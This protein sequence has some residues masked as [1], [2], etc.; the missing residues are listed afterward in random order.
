MKFYFVRFKDT[1]NKVYDGIMIGRLI[2]ICQYIKE[3]G[4]R[5]SHTGLRTMPDDDFRKGNCAII[6]NTAEE[7]AE[8]LCWVAQRRFGDRLPD[9]Y[10]TNRDKAKWAIKT[11]L[12]RAM[13]LFPY[14]ARETMHIE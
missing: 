4:T 12:E 6:N 14:Q 3:D 9:H 1:C 8:D 13:S 10:T 5:T 11:I 7:L 2:I